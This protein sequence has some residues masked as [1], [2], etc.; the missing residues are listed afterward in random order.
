MKTLP[1]LCALALCVSSAAADVVPAGSE[2][3]D[4]L[5]KALVNDDYAAFIADGDA[6]FKG[7]TKEQ[8]EGAVKLLSERLK[9]GYEVTWLGE[10]KQKGF[11]VSLWKFT[12]KDGGDDLLGTLSLKDGKVGGFWIK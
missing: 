5:V 6:S 11:A 4:K 8:F 3:T 12:F 9:G 10:L 1:I 7:L 2:V